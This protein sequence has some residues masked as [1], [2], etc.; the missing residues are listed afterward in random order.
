MDTFKRQLFNM[1]GKESSLLGL[2]NILHLATPD[3][4]SGQV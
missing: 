4:Y 2:F 3:H 1:F